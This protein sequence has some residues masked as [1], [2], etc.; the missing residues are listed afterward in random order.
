MLLEGAPECRMPPSMRG[1]Q[2]MLKERD[3]TAPTARDTLVFEK[4]VPPD[5]YLRRV[6]QRLD[7]E[8]WRDRVKD[9]DSPAMGR[10]AA[11]P[12]R[13]IKRAF[14]PCHDHRSAREVIAAAQVNVAFRYVLA[15]SLESRV[16]VP[17]VLTQLRTRLGAQ[18]PQARF[19][20]RVTQAREWGW[21]RAR[22]RLKDAT[23]V[24]ANL[25]VPSTL[26]LVA[27][28]RPRLLA[29]ARP[30]TVD[31]GA[32]EEAEAERLRQ[33]TAALP[34]VDRL[35]HRVAHLRAIVAGADALQPDL[36]P[37]PA[38]PDTAR[39]HVEAAVA[40]A[41]RLLADREDPDKG[42]QVRS[43]VAA[44]A[45]CGK[46]GAS[47]EGYRRDIRVDADSAR[48]TALHLL[49][50][51]GD[52]ARAAQTLR[53]AEER[54]QDHAREAVS[55]EGMG[56]NGE[57]LRALPA[58][59]GMGV[60][61]FVP[62]PPEPPETP[63]FRPEAVSWR[64]SGA[65]SR[66]PGANRR[67]RRRAVPTTPG[68]RVS[69]PAASVPGVPGTR[70][71]NCGLPRREADGGELLVEPRMRAQREE[72]IPAQPRRGGAG[73]GARMPG[74]LGLQ[75]PRRPRFFQRDFPG[76]APATPGADRLRGL[77]PGGRQQRLGLKAL[78]GVAT[79]HPADG[80]R[81][82]TG[83]I[84]HGRVAGDCHR[85]GAVPLPRCHGPLVPRRVR[86]GPSG[87]QGRTPGSLQ[88]RAPAWPR[89]T[90]RRWIRAGGGATPAWDEPGPA[91]RTARMEPLPRRITAVRDPDP[92]PSRPPTDHHRD[93]LP[94]PRHEG[95]RT[96]GRRRIK[97]LGGTQ[98]R[99]PRESPHPG[100]PAH[101]GQ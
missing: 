11:D 98:P 25:A 95:L 31:R 79:E 91:P 49:P 83:V 82:R 57:V 55:M 37:L 81:R 26:R 41:Q 20:Q 53:A 27:H 24:L 54:A 73:H 99:H 33:A 47:C 22:L 19:D 7:G 43:V 59:E 45:R 48:L 78:R 50:G 35:A 68:G 46:P 13:M 2:G 15:L 8:R 88:P 16:P 30:Y 58:P 23:P 36:G 5:H 67:P 10:T 4:L 28:T 100:S 85:A 9:G 18:R 97:R 93:A 29:A 38:S 96:T 80:D 34:D 51:N 3:D 44:D 42:D 61:G 70:G 74:A 21:I 64:P 12:V 65:S 101:G 72:C 86:L 39:P 62:P 66:V 52:E 69:W 87:L 63:L 90:W 76:P 14:R 71:V 92:D 56:W 94:G 32:A 89:G 6:T 77:V 1:G 84:P 17:S 75:A 60:E 40:L